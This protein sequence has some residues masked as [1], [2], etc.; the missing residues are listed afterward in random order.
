M[1]DRLTDLAADLRKH[2]AADVHLDLATRLLYSTDASS[3]QILPL[4]VVVPK[5][6]DDVLATVEACQRQDLLADFS[7]E[8]VT[9]TIWSAG[10]GLAELLLNGQLRDLGIETTPEAAAQVAAAVTQS[11]R[12]GLWHRAKT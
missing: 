3:Y 8:H 10:H 7:V 9:L 2:S 1:T 5:H 12:T 4:A 11:I 6:Y